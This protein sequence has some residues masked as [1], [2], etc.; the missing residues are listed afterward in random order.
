MLTARIENLFSHKVGEHGIQPDTEVKL[1]ERR[2]QVADAIAW[3]ISNGDYGFINSL[4]N[5]SLVKQVRSYLS[6]NRWVRTLVVIGIG[7]SDL[8]GRTI[9]Q[10][11]AT[12][13]PS[14]S[15]NVDV[16]FHGDST[17]PSDLTW[18]LQRVNINTT[19][20]NIVSKSGSTMETMAQYVYLKEMLQDRKP[21][22]WSKH[23]VFTTDPNYGPLNEQSKQFDIPMMK[24]PDDVGGRFSVLTP[25][26]TLP[27]AALG[28][29]IEQMIAGAQSVVGQ[30]MDNPNDST[31]LLIAWSQYLLQLQG[32]KTAVIMPYS[33]RLTE[34]ARW[35]RQL[36]AESLGKQGTGILP[37]QARGPADQ[38]SQL[39]FYT[40]GELLSSF[41][42]INIRDHDRSHH[43]H[44][45][46][47]EGLEYLSGKNFA[48][49]IN[50]EYQATKGSLLNSG[51]PNAT[52]EI[53][54]LNA[55][56]LGELFM[57]FELAVVCLG[58]FME[59]NPFDQ[60]GVQESKDMIYALL[61]R[62]GYEEKL[63]ELQVLGIA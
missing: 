33:T 60:P 49:L 51:R 12:E 40:E 38:H 1:K 27:G 31:P 36:W 28:A 16:I 10:A 35:F 18:M 11:L 6:K 4:A 15:P 63:R 44:N 25:V 37:I 42:F 55:F 29:D 19:A 45:S 13:S 46:D 43:I 2:Q 20:F 3:N 9:R 57:T 7:G 52:I 41:W 21:R 48:D 50:I 34:F 47:V 14:Q 56:T 53:D 5:E 30:F 32:I 17:D 39:Q 22:A 61:G 8:G 58:E 54:D 24:I 59:I 23:F 26:G 62:D